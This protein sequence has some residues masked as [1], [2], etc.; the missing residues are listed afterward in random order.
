M[1]AEVQ[2]R[3]HRG[4][5]STALWLPWILFVYSQ[6]LCEYSVF[7][8]LHWL[9]AI[10]RGLPAS[11]QVM[12]LAVCSIKLWA[13]GTVSRLH[14]SVMLVSK[15]KQE[16][17]FSHPRLVERD[18]G[19]EQGWDEEG[20][21]EVPTGGM[22]GTITLESPGKGQCPSASHPSLPWQ[23]LCSQPIPLLLL[24]HIIHLWT[25]TPLSPSHSPIWATATS[26]QG[27]SPFY[28]QHDVPREGRDRTGVGWGW[29]KPS[30]VGCC[31]C[32]QTSSVIFTFL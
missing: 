30:G 18:R 11:A 15:T 1:A 8:S 16:D 29:R 5:G 31:D 22:D 24:L 21:R 19:R 27:P 14:R 10:A 17:S 13:C 32:L 25:E 26:S 2:P 6:G 3:A 9:T 4:H 12:F 28:L 20:K 7:S 23:Y